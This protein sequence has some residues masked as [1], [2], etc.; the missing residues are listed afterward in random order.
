MRTG[1]K[2]MKY[3]VI[4]AVLLSMAACS[5]RYRNH[6]YVPSDEELAA[7]TLGVDTRDTVAEAIGPPSASGV[8]TDSGFFYV[9][10]RIKHY[11]PKRPEVVDRQV[12]AIGFDS[13]GI[14]RNVEHY[15]LEDGQVVPLSRRVTDNGIQSNG[16][17]RQL[18]G[19]IGN[20]GPGSGAPSGNGGF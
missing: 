18:I 4:G 12:V 13:R 10:T 11:G 20:F 14:A 1:S 7:I 8:L 2:A 6:G 3:A 17:I 19:N 15:A 5:T 9:R 16:L